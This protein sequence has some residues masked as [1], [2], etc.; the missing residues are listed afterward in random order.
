MLKNSTTMKQD[1]GGVIP[2]NGLTQNLWICKEILPTSL[3]L[4]RH[5]TNNH[6]LRSS[7][8]CVEH[9]NERDR[10]ELQSEED[11]GKERIC[12]KCWVG[13]ERQGGSVVIVC[14]IILVLVSFIFVKIFGLVS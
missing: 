7:L 2:L 6:N 5:T 10:R 13:C 11:I 12:K 9:E 3:L 4:N 1:K 14:V 8:N